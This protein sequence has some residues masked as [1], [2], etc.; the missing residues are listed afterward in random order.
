MATK[1]YEQVSARETAL[2]LPDGRA[3]PGRRL[4][5]SFRNGLLAQARKVLRKNGEE[6]QIVHILEELVF[7]ETAIAILV[8]CLCQTDLNAERD[9]MSADDVLKAFDAWPGLMQEWGT[10]LALGLIGH[11]GRNDLPGKEVEKVESPLP[12][13]PETETP[14]SPVLD[15]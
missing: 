3:I 5:L 12:S 2:T 1:Y 6:R 11:Y 13:T 4:R 9:K 8:Q 14:A 7:D 15:G 10:G